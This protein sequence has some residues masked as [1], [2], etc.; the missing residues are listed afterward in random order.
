MEAAARLGGASSFIAKLPEGYDTY[1]DRPVHDYF[2]GIPEG[3]K[4]LFG[5]TVDY[6]AVRSA[7]GMPA[8]SAGGPTLSGGQ[9]QRLAV[10]RTFMRSVVS[11]DATVGLLLF[12]EPSASLDPTAEHGTRFLPS[13]VRGSVD[14][15]DV[16]ICLRDCG[17]CEET[18]RWCFRRTGS[19]T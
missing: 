14:G 2:S 9:M 6:A 11:E 3:T 12:D 15:G 16:Q 8:R 7:G 1:L 13:C 17:N 18:R 4:T 5:R 10:S 19:G